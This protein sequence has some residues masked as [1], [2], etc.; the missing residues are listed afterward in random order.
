MSTDDH[1]PEKPEEKER[2]ERFGGFV[3]AL[4]DEDGSDFGPNRVWNMSMT[5]P[6]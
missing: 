5:A 2:I 3:S 6:G 4:K 1:R